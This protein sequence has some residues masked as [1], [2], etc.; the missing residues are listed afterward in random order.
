MFC[1]TIANYHDP[2]LMEYARNMSHI[3]PGDLENLTWCSQDRGTAF[4]MPPYYQHVQEKYWGVGLFSYWEFRKIPL[5]FVAAP[6][7]GF[8]FYGAIDLLFDMAFDAR[9]LVVRL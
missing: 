3:M 9:R 1:E 4:I 2:V 5:F 7:I 6:T 8:I